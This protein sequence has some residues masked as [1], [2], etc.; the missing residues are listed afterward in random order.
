MSTA[1]KRIGR[2]DPS[3]LEL[4]WQDGHRT[5]Y[6]TAE[7]R[8]LCPCARCIHELTGQALLDP[9]SVPEELTHNGVQLVGTYAL[10][11]AFSD[12]HSTGIFTWPMLRENDP[13][14]STG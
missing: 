8:R 3:R 4:E 9:A 1:P 11:V 12:G 10:S 14:S 6:S 2:R 13:A 7:L 5:V